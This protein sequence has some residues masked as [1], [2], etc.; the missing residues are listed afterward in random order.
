MR[1]VNYESGDAGEAAEFLG[2][3]GRGSCGGGFAEDAEVVGEDVD[4][5]AG[6]SG[7]RRG[8]FQCVR[9]A[10]ITYVHDGDLRKGVEAEREIFLAV[11][12]DEQHAGY[13]GVGER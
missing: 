13:L 3:C 12:L 9:A 10:R 2:V 5:S 11:A 7:R 8:G 4:F 6:L 1:N